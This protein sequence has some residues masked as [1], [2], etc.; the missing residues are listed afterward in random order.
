MYY[1]TA[2][3]ILPAMHGLAGLSDGDPTLADNPL[4]RSRILLPG[5]SK[6]TPLCRCPRAHNPSTSVET[7][8]VSTSSTASV[9]LLSLATL[10]Y[11][12]FYLHLSISFIQMLT[13]MN[14][15]RM[16]N[17]SIAELYQQH[18]QNPTVARYAP[19][20]FYIASAGASP[21]SCFHQ[22]KCSFLLE[23]SSFFA[24][25]DSNP[26]SSIILAQWMLSSPK[27]CACCLCLS[28][29]ILSPFSPFSLLPV[30][31]FPNLD[32]PLPCSSSSG[33]DASGKVRI[34]DTTQAE[35]ILKNEFHLLGGPILDMAWSDDS[36]RIAVVGQGKEKF[37]AVV[38]SD[39]GAS[40][41]EISGH[42]K[43]VS[44]V[45]LKQTR[46]YR[47]ITGSEDLAVNFFE[48]PP[49]KFKKAFKE[50]QRFVNAVRFSP[51]GEKFI[52]V[53]SD[54]S[55]FLF[56][57]KTGDKLGQLDASEG[58]KSG[59]YDAAWSPD[60]DKVLTVSADKTAKLWDATTYKC[61]AT[62]PLGNDT[63]DQQLGCIWNGASGEV[64]TISLSGYINFLDINTPDKPKKIVR[65]HNKLI[66]A[67][68]YDRVGRKVYSGDFGARLLE[69]DVDSAETSVFSGKGHENQI[70]AAVVSGDKLY[71]ISMDDSLKISSI[72]DKT[73]G[74][75]LALDLQPS[76]LAVSS[77]GS[78]LSV[79][80]G[81]NTIIVVKGGKIASR[82]TVKF[83]VTKVAINSDDTEV[84]VGGK[85]F[86]VHVY[87]I[88]AGTNAVDHK[89]DLTDHRGEITALEYSHDG[90]YLAVGDGNREV[91]AWRGQERKSNGWV[92]HTTRINSISWSPDNIHIASVGTDSNLIVWNVAEPNSRIVTKN[93]HYGGA[94]EVVWIDGNTALTGGQDCSLKAW[95]FKY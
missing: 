29:S 9:T 37:G 67:L 39:T 75:S 81:G 3:T 87:A 74:E 51:N 53:S 89:Y 59:V 92:F 80:V 63:D 65:G 69:W 70:S 10:R 43:T 60:S 66:T 41:G 4:A 38:F 30:P 85:D 25:M 79:V 76:G 77:S 19:S 17:I 6:F 20:G 61:L 8:R 12:P 94:T 55:C 84:A 91:I 7:R 33:T 2:F 5:Q 45:D 68:A 31:L 48:G 16:K 42:S 52:S 28:R 49:F 22:R 40:V 46:P 56:D 88:N 78:G 44:T 90:Q 21:N 13:L 93:A 14:Y 50:H 34:W 95:T 36:K 27:P 47:L 57:G 54:K 24:M 71:T 11:V 32:V 58:H 72:A 62:F 18:A 35:H 23:P 15:C 1:L 64:V 82:T 83:D 26:L 86:K 73:W